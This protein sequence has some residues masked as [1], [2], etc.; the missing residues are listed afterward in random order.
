MSRRSRRAS[1]SPVPASDQ[2][3][4][5]VIYFPGS[6][7]GN[8]EP[9]EAEQLLARFRR[10][11]GAFGIVVLGIDLKKSRA[12]LHAAYNDAQGITAVFNRNVLARMNRAL[13]ADFDVE[14]FAHYAF[15]EPTEGRIE[16][17]LVSLCR[18]AVTVAGHTFHFREGES[19]RTECSYKYD[20]PGA[21][22]LARRAGL[23]LIDA[24]LDDE[25]RFAVLEPR[26]MAPVA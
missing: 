15:Y 26:P 6:T 4:R 8:F 20:L 2:G 10:A 5:T 3:A 16:M 25:R 9:G 14:A 11:A 1:P 19:V 17:H 12:T 7:I 23:H 13:D 22:R 24:W 18:Q 21:E